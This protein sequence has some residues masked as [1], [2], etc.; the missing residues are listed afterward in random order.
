MRRVLLRHTQPWYI[1][2]AAVAGIA[3]VGVVLQQIPITAT[4]FASIR[5]NWTVAFVALVAI[6]T[7]WFG[8]RSGLLAA[9]T[10]ALAYNFFFI[11]PVY[12]FTV[13]P[14]ASEYLLWAS[15]VACALLMRPAM[16][17]WVAAELANTVV[18]RRQHT[19]TIYR[20]RRVHRERRDA[21]T[22][23][24]SL[25]TRPG[26]SNYTDYL[27]AIRHTEAL[28]AELDQITAEILAGP[29][30]C[31]TDVAVLAELATAHG[32]RSDRREGG[33]CTDKASEVLEAMLQAA[34]GLGPKVK[35]G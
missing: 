10:S 2:I 29:V 27:Q 7:A 21:V 23:E 20:L 6:N 17:N 9:A 1:S 35:A 26:Q 30:R 11:E 25:E 4:A 22:R 12:E 8:P 3:G 31:W 5:D 15:M 16:R 19:D 33:F 24:M 34:V 14:Q 28:S 13:P 32:A 18:S